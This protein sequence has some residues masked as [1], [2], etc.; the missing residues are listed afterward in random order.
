[1]AAVF[2]GAGS[3]AQAQVV[4]VSNMQETSNLDVAVGATPGTRIAQGFRTGTNSAGYTLSAVSIAMKVNDFTAGERLTLR[5]YSS[6]S[7]TPNAVV[8]TLTTPA[9]Y[10][11]GGVGVFAAPAGATL[12]AN[13]SYHVVFQ[14]SGDSSFDAVVHTTNS[15][16]QTG[17][18]GWTIDNDSRFPLP[19]SLGSIKIRV[20]GTI[21]I[22][23]TAADGAVTT[24][25]DTAYTFSDDD[26][27]YSGANA[28]DTPD[29]VTVVTLPASAVGTLTLSGAAVRAEDE[30]TS[31]AL[32]AGNLRFVPVADANGGT[33]FT[34][35][36]SDGLV[37]SATATMT[38]NV[39][40]VNDPA[41]GEPGISGTASVGHTLTADATGIMD[42][43]G[44]GAF[45]YQWLRVDGSEAPINGA[46]NRT[47]L[48][49]AADAGKQVKVRVSFTDGNNTSESRTSAAFPAV[50]TVA[51]PGLRVTG[52][53]DLVT[54]EAGG[55]ATF[56]VAL[57]SQPLARVVV[58]L[59]SSDTGEGTISPAALT[60]TDADWSTAQTVTVTGV[61]DSDQDGDQEYRITFAVTSTDTHYTGLS[62]D[63]VT[64]TNVN[65]DLV[66]HVGRVAGD[67]T[68]NLAEQRSGFTITGDTGSEPDV[69]VTVE[70]GP[71]TLTT[72]SDADGNWSVVLQPNSSYLT[73][74][75]PNLFVSLRK[76]GLPVA[77]LPTVERELRLD[78]V[79]PTASYDAPSSLKVGVSLT[80]IDPG[81][82]SNDIDSYAS[83]TL[84]AGLTVHDTEGHILGTPTAAGAASTVTVTVT[85][86][87]GNASQVTIDFPEVEK[88][89]Q[90]LAG[91]AYD[92]D[93]LAPEGLEGAKTTLS[94]ATASPEVCTVDAV[95]GALTV[96]AAGMCEITVTAA[97]T[98]D[99]NQATAMATVTV[100]PAV[101]LSLTLDP[102]TGDDTVNI[103]EGGDGF[104]L[105]GDTGSVADVT[106]T[107]MTGAHS[108]STTSGSDGAWS[109]GVGANA[110]FL[111]EPSVVLTVDAS[112][113]GFGAA[114]LTRTL[115][116][117]LT[118]PAATYA[119][120]SGLQ[121]GAAMTAVDPAGMSSDIVSYA[122]TTLPAGLTVDSMTGRISGTPTAAG[123][124]STV[125]VTVTDRAGNEVGVEIDFPAVAKADQT[126]TG[127]AYDQASVMFGS[128]VPA[129]ASP[130]GATTSLSY[131][132]EPPGVCSV[133]PSTGALTLVDVGD[134]T[135]TVTAAATDNYNEASATTTVTVEPA[136]GLV[137]NVEPVAGN[138]VVNIA[139]K[140]DGFRVHGNTGAQ[141]GATVTVRLG[142]ETLP[143]ATSSGSPASWSVPVP[144]A[145]SYVTGTSLVLTV[146]A[147]KPGYTAAAD[148]VRTL[149][150][151]LAPPSVSY[152]SPDALQVDVATEVTP[153]SPNPDDIASY[154]ATGLPAGLTLDA[155]SG[156]ISGTPTA[157]GAASTVTVTVTDNAEN[158]AEVEIS[159]PA[160]AKGDQT[161]TNFAYNPSSV[162][163]T[164]TPSPESGPNGVKTTLT[165][166]TESAA[167]CTVDPGT[168]ELDFVGLGECVVKATAASDANYN[169]AS[170]TFTV[171]V[172]AAGQL[173]LTS[174]APVAGD[175]VVNISERADGFTLSGA[176]NQ[177]GMTVALNFGQ[178]DLDATTDTS[179]SW[180]VAVP[181]NAAYLTEPSVVLTV[182]GRKT[183]YTA[184]PPVTRTVRV[185]LAAPTVSY[186]APSS[187]QVDVELM[188]SPETDDTD[189]ASYVAQGLPLGL[190]IATDT[191]TIAGT[192]TKAVTATTT[193]T[194]TV[195]DDASNTTEVFVSFPQV[196]K[197]EQPLEGFAYSA[198]QVVH[199]QPVP[200][201]TAPSGWK[202]SLSY[203]AAPP[204]VCTVTAEA[205]ELSVLG[206]GE[207]VIT[208][209][210]AADDD[211]NEESGTYTV[212]V[213]SAGNLALNVAPVAGDDVVSI[214][215]RAAGFTLTGDT[216]TESGV[217]VRVFLGSG[218]LDGESG[219]GGSWSVLV[220]ANAAYLVEPD[221][222]LTVQAQKAGFNAADDEERTVRVDLT[223]PAVS[224]TVP[225][226]LQVDVELTMSPET[227]DTDVASY[228]AQ[229]LPAGLEI[230]A[231][232]GEI[233]G[234][235]TTAAPGVTATVTA[236]DTAGN[237]AL[238]TVVFPEVL[239]GDQPLT[240][241]GY[242]AASAVYG[243]LV[244][245]RTGPNGAKTA[246]SY[247]AAPVEVCG[248]DSAGV[249]SLLDVGECVITVTAEET[250]DYN[251]SSA[252]AT[253]DVLPAGT[254]V[255]GVL[256]VAED[257][258]V[259]IEEKAEGFTVSGETGSQGDVTVTVRIG[260]ETL[261]AV[262][263]A[264]GSWTAAV[265]A[266]AAYIAE[267]S[268]VL[269]ASTRKTG[270]TASAEV[271]KTLTVDLTAP[272]VAY[273]QVSSLKVAERM[274]EMRP[275]GPS[276][277]TASYRAEE[278]P[279][280]LEIAATTG[281]ITGIP[282][283]A[284]S[285][286]QATVTATD[287]AGNETAVTLSFGAVTKGDQVLNGFRYSAAT[288]VFD[289]TVPALAAPTGAVTGLS[290]RARPVGVCNADAT[291]GALT[292]VGLGTCVITVTAA[293]SDNYNEASETFTLTV[294]AAG[295]LAL[296]LG[297]VAGD[298]VVNVAEWREGFVLG[299][300]TGAEEDVSVTVRVGAETLNATSGADGQWSATVTP[301][302]SYL[303]EPSVVL[304]VSGSKV[305]LTAATDVV[306]T[307]AVDLTAPAA[308]YT[309]P[310]ALQVGV[311]MA[312]AAP[313]SD[314]VDIASYAAEGLP[315]GLVLD[316]GTGV[317]GGTPTAA[318]AAATVTVTVTDGAGNAT[319]VAL[320]FPAVS[321]GNRVV[322][323]FAYSTSMAVL[324]ETAPTVTPPT[325]TGAS[326]EVALRYAATPPAVCTVGA[327]TGTLTPVG[328][329]ECVVTV[330]VA[331]TDDYNA[332]AS[333]FTVTVSAT[334]PLILNVGSIAGDGAVNIGEQLDGFTVRGD[335]GSEGGASVT[336]YVGDNYLKGTSDSAG[337]WTVAVPGREDYVAEPS[338]ELTV[339]A[340]KVGFSAP[341]DVVRTVAVDLTRPRVSYT[342]PADLF[343]GVA[344]SPMSPVTTDT[345]IVSYSAPNLPAGLV[346]DGSTGVISGA[347]TTRGPVG[348][349]RVYVTDSAGNEG[350]VE[351]R[352]PAVS[353]PP[354]MLN[355]GSIAG[356]GAV[357]IGERGDGFTVR[358]DTGSEGGVSVTVYVGDN[359]LK[360]TSDSAGTWTVA[361]PGREDYV[362]EPSFE[363]TVV[364]SKVGFSA[365]QDV[366]RTVAVDLTMPRVSYTVPADLFE[367]V[368]ISP[369]SPVTTDTDIVSYSA[370]NLPA[371][372]VIDGSTGVISGAPTTRGP[373]GRLRVYVTDS[374]GNEGAVELR[375]P[376]VSSPP[377]MLNVGS[378]AGDGAVNIGERGD[379]FTVRG[380]TGSEGGASVTVYVGDNYLKGTSDSAGTWTVAV[381]GREDY[382]AEPSFEL[383]VVASKVGFSAPQDV[384][385]TVAVDL[386]M[387]RVS[388][389]V[390]ADLFQGVAIS[391]MS[392][393][394]TDT[395]IVSY[396]APNLPAGLVI[397]GSTGVISGTPTG[398]GAVGT[399]TVSVVDRAGNSAAVTVAFPAV[400][401]RSGAIRSV[402][403][404]EPPRDDGWRSGDLVTIT[405]TF[406][407]TVFVETRQGTPWVRLSLL[408]SGG[409]EVVRRAPYVRGSGTTSLTFVYD[410]VA[411]DGSATTVTVPENGL[412]GAILD[413]TGGPVDIRHAGTT[414]PTAAVDMTAPSVSYTVP[415]DLFQ[416][417]AISP[418]GPVT[419]D[420]DIVSYSAPNLPAGLVIDGST[421]VISGTPTGQGAVGTVTVS[422]VDRAGNSAAVTVAFP[423]VSVR[424]GAIRSVEVGEPPRD[425]G[426]RSGDL[427]TITVTFY[428]TVYVETRQGTPWV[429][430]SLLGSDGSEVVRRAPYVR[431][432]RTTSLTFVYD[433]V[434]ADGSATTVTVPENGLGGAI[435]D[436][437][438]GP[439][440]IR[441]A[442]TTSPTEQAAT[443][444]SDVEVVPPPGNEEVWQEGDDVEV[445]VNFGR[446]VNVDTSQG[447]PWVNVVLVNPVPPSNSGLLRG[448]AAWARPIR[449]A[450]FERQAY[451]VRG[452][453]T[454]SLTFAYEL[455]EEDGVVT[456]VVV[457]DNAL[458]LG[459]AVIRDEAGEEVEI[460]HLGTAPMD[461]EPLSVLR[462]TDA[463][464]VE[465]GTLSFRVTLAPAA[466]EAVTVEWETRAGSAT[467]GSD[468]ADSSGMLE[469][470]PGETVKAVSVAVRADDVMEEVETLTLVLSNA[471]GAEIAD[472]EAL[473]TI[474]DG[475]GAPRGWAAR[476]GRTV[477][478]QVTDAVDRHLTANRNTGL[479]LRVA[480]QGVGAAPSETERAWTSGG[481][482]A[483]WRWRPEDGVEP[484]LWSRRA[485]TGRE[486][487]TGTS[488][489]LS[490]GTEAGGVTSV[491]GRGALSRFEGGTADAVLD[492]QVASG[493]LGADWSTA[494]WTAGVLLAH[495]RG[496][497]DYSLAQGPGTV[498][499]TLTG[500]YP[501]GRL[502]LTP[503][504]SLWGV[505][506]LGRGE[507]SFTAP[508]APEEETGI[509]MTMAAGGGSGVV[510]APETSGGLEVALKAEVM[511]VRTEAESV[512]DA[513]PSEKARMTRF[514]V[515]VEGT[516]HGLE[517]NGGR[518]TPTLELGVRHD[519]GDAEIGFGAEAG[520]GLSW[521]VPRQG[522]QAE[523]RAR[524]LL[525]HEDAGLHEYGLMASFTWDREPSSGRGPSLKLRQTVGTTAGGG[526]DELFSRG[527]PAGVAG[528]DPARRFKARLGYGLPAFGDRFTGTPRVG[529]ALSDMHREYSLGWRLS[530]MRRPHALVDL[531][532]EGT[533]RERLNGE[534]E[535]DRGIGLRL[536][537]RW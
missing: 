275:D 496:D 36:V 516:W 117:D 73:E 139:E 198:N 289:Q 423:A 397:D 471:G 118:A 158:E 176:G 76:A 274:V 41:T 300:D 172:E 389:T 434:A 192:P 287:G 58:G 185:D 293:E 153:S 536:R 109:V 112:K 412:G 250:A 144:A 367:G 462:A 295:R 346:I 332:A 221:V 133:D 135:V 147:E 271:E 60:F 307:V 121:F 531:D 418:M 381:P 188:M 439:V 237:P 395:D 181:A 15:D 249:L 44:M 500:L 406:Y 42:A 156:A 210:A 165:Y 480:G 34:F 175:N 334:R 79:L 442:G 499:G 506:G 401:V 100:S 23:P 285:A 163:F 204:E 2:L 85:D 141:D 140:A 485:L 229:G 259:N 93:S 114:S 227:D 385:R 348:R 311:A 61:D 254:L 438:G 404:G 407:G 532:I 534:S 322:N 170:V 454:M 382:V 214:A 447:T 40:P 288:V 370:P 488:F 38:V 486:L 78:L 162:T 343:Q 373:V 160:V 521:A 230:D 222:A 269:T 286:A 305:G 493:M 255:L 98:A 354:L 195:T 99:Y 173:A 209:T 451:Y 492:G 398:Q 14:G 321:K 234:T 376:A 377:L 26:F 111:A 272:S 449:S 223:A 49:D 335:T 345:D 217:S 455:A 347:P 246:L 29:S 470:A 20:T 515:G 495:A 393:A 90:V 231:A 331:A 378:I 273:L 86:L 53:T 444:V 5:I 431:G 261:S 105:S 77:N 437:A 206:V 476:F 17:A 177:G 400:S 131:A 356:D 314:D 193:A 507:M 67:D 497:G 152:T 252:T 226:S 240:G 37:E 278:L 313:A 16:A 194:V 525:F 484:G 127:F 529:F 57:L 344:I 491:W 116:V 478:E 276:P 375:F 202:T 402:E 146:S 408:G 365:P 277:D 142:S 409:S 481:P 71:N 110:A 494:L 191:G 357:N 383:T 164:D 341:Q 358:G 364:A 232:A 396:S 159:L 372:L 443:S 215:D 513:F 154:V 353:S 427:V 115:T 425:D 279:A 236:T 473:G 248:V 179:G 448:W 72:T 392:P 489:R 533:W 45:S 264:D 6:S 369:M 361:V 25:E 32:V 239:K 122:S 505:V 184:A 420:T 166:S 196:D 88:G 329:G 238:Q 150:V 333:T 390:P 212:V 235:P 320:A 55:T 208:V 97:G 294:L 297:D 218:T 518:W 178:G 33:T 247:A 267:P 328:P 310:A 101:T 190:T 452:S 306:R 371:G 446:V 83:T 524:R 503:W 89:D 337:T 213:L 405:V 205:G 245:T 379:G 253:V 251:E 512:A 4:L 501:Y 474:L 134:C 168:G 360:G 380:D 148:H 27:N 113:V 224:Y 411:A 48:L 349:L 228:E 465:G 62:V 220:P 475:G 280:G 149:S 129:V 528:N 445:V 477:A 430:L 479:E 522:V 39:T 527:T 128:S 96:L 459:G 10:P 417:V 103:V 290:Y 242:S 302:A 28:G 312:D 464:A 510:L 21:N 327:E 183:G 3:V 323:G 51:G 182:N 54:T 440:D 197:G 155:S 468:Y 351:L 318:A 482:A 233:S 338:F 316:S 355:V 317:I 200:T 315:A 211:Y 283:T 70:V 69:A 207:C 216:G 424:S 266:D 281:F 399:V 403:V 472:G 52:G 319:D 514:G 268:V 102:V 243:E 151:D 65:D 137:L 244:P 467:P 363:L 119:S 225:L 291:T 433:L 362:A 130:S 265:P 432:S 92:P 263:A 24:D 186:P 303:S 50:G 30:V 145:A 64:A 132:A 125:T 136:G 519:G 298:D 414:S 304:T 324:G 187:L 466:S 435:L 199:G 8:H 171:T 47:Y 257:D 520:V 342:V 74:G 308:S 456:D 368:A 68:I 535:P 498:E 180:S 124:A 426:W 19:V 388:Y 59:A 106:L 339:V 419:T 296:N 429:R 504:L 46:T 161:L 537:L 174:L 441:H 18:A 415:A 487:L 219:A 530:P 374:A 120:P 169:E 511:A 428:G 95:S 82:A 282:T 483:A 301:E 75:G 138:D 143:T 508:G 13:T 270:Y 12:A 91:F 453:G 394:T 66:L 461:E 31:A 422:V 63:A 107:V 509:D 387:P 502:R 256:P 81:N 104:S 11:A 157:A 80:Q 366:V 43:D 189:L 463:R 330:S 391:P 326:G 325:V 386:T 352:F 7:N 421:G 436:V 359:Y 384:V 84:P 336:V 108:L 1:M 260:G 22:A 284:G 258:V 87:A 94:Y 241:F 457:P 292:L 523:L 413:V 9:A 490:A 309:A 460:R 469:F 450:E 416:G 167:V 517:V 350:A 203:A 299:G 262:S 35:R 56:Q 526:M 458:V 340:S 126:L 410:L 201:V 123:A